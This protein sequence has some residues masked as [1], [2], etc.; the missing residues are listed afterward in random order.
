M[1]FKMNLKH[2]TNSTVNKNTVRVSLHEELERF[3]LNGGRIIEYTPNHSSEN[4]NKDELPVSEKCYSDLKDEFN[5]TVNIQISID[6]SNALKAKN[7]KIKISKNPKDSELKVNKKPVKEINPTKEKTTIKAPIIKSNSAKKSKSVK[8][9]IPD[10]SEKQSK[11]IKE[12]KPTE[13]KPKRTRNIENQSQRMKVKKDATRKIRTRS[14]TFEAK[15]ENKRRSSITIAKRIAIA[16][17]EK[18]FLAECKIH[19]MT[20]Y[21]IYENKTCR[22]IECIQDARENSKTVDEKST[23]YR[24]KLNRELALKASE[25]DQKIFI[26]LCVYHDR[27]PHVVESVSVKYT[28]KVKYRCYECKKLSKF[29]HAI[30]NPVC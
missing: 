15:A 24:L 3:L 2:T 29:K 10:N 11:V 6:K 8:K 27:S 12:K 25:S 7:Q 5:P 17:G 4:P 21:L 20:N 19:K 13:N 26:G 18:Y 9:T 30:N 16:N 28:N 23:S 22:C 14:I 1:V